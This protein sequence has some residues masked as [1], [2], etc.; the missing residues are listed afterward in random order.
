[1]A[2]RTIQGT[3]KDETGEPMSEW[4]SCALPA[5][6]VNTSLDSA[7]LGYTIIPYSDTLPFSKTQ[8]DYLGVKTTTTLSHSGDTLKIE[9]FHKND[10]LAS[11]Q[12]HMDSLYHFFINGKIS[13][14]EYRLHYRN[15]VLP[16]NKSTVTSDS[17]VVYH[18]NGR[19][20][21]IK[22]R[23]YDTGKRRYRIF[24]ETGKLEKDYK[25]NLLNPTTS[26]LYVT[27][28][29]GR[30]EAST[31]FSH[32]LNY[33]HIHQRIYDTLFYETGAIKAVRHIQNGFDNI[34]IAPQEL[35]SALYI[36]V[37]EE[38]MESGEELKKEFYML[39]IF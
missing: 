17:I 39:Q 25:E 38:D 3:V 11:C 8:V 33:P 7:K 9:I 10:Q 26:Y 14:K 35:L 24:D 28:N 31:L 19:I 6:I 30:I 18:W 15:E 20:K 21:S 2:Q 1:M 29:M 36:W 22:T 12:W 34:E 16:W 27:N 37:M 13:S 5:N 4:V 32:E 23:N